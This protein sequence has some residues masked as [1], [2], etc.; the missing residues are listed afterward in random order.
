MESD[1]KLDIT[2]TRSA[3]DSLRV[4]AVVYVRQKDSLSLMP[5][6]KES[7]DRW[8]YGDIYSHGYE[9]NRMVGVKGVYGDKPEPVPVDKDLPNFVLVIPPHSEHQEYNPYM[10]I[11]GQWFELDSQSGDNRMIPTSHETVLEF[12][13]Q[14]DFHVA[15]EGE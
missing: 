11:N 4:G 8:V 2:F 14:D 10:L 6:R 1:Q 15:F 3:L 5:F 9:T 12:I 13:N 7:K